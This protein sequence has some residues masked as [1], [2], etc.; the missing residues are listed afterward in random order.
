M[1]IET[2]TVT[3]TIETTD[4]QG[5]DFMYIR[6]NPK[7]SKIQSKTVAIVEG[8]VTRANPIIDF[9]DPLGLAGIKAICKLVDKYKK[10]ME[11]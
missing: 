2:S 6:A 1:I 9:Y 10:E 8:I 5:G 4:N 3:Y 11:G 7:C